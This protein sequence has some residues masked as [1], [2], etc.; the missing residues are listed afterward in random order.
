MKKKLRLFLILL[1]CL[2]TVF[3]SAGAYTLTDKF[4][5]ILEVYT[6]Y[7]LDDT[8]EPELLR[9]LLN[10][11]ITH[12]PDTFDTVVSELVKL[13]DPYSNYFSVDQVTQQQAA[14]TS[15]GIGVTLR[16]VN[17][18]FELVSV[19]E[20]TPAHYVGLKAGDVIRYINGMSTRNLTVGVLGML[21]NGEQGAENTIHFT[22]GENKYRVTLK[23][24]IIHASTVSFEALT[25]EVGYVR[26]T[27][28]DAELNTYADFRVACQKLADRGCTRLLIDV[29]DN[30]GGDTS[31]MLNMINLLVPQKGV[32]L[33]SFA[34][35]GDEKEAYHS[36]GSSLAF[37][38]VGVLVNGMSISA[39]ECMAYA[40]QQCGAATVIGQ[41]TFGKGVGQYVIPLQDGSMLS[42]TSLR[43]ENAR[44]ETYHGT[45]VKPDIEVLNTTTP[46]DTSTLLP[47]TQAQATAL[48]PGD[49]G[50]A[51]RAL[52]QRMVLMGY[53]SA[54]E[55][56]YDSQL[57]LVIKLFQQACKLEETGRIDNATYGRLN[58]T[59]NYLASQNVT[60]DVQ[61]ETALEWAGR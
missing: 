30:G 36:T 20:G 7:H 1:I 55:D 50:D 23:N 31:Q 56:V 52:Q 33:I 40:L 49:S 58:S 42:V 19:E 48:R 14:K 34:S 17:G 54:V 39:A 35:K 24:D 22:R 18:G 59:I 25:D 57:E 43:A 61:L 8:P 28:F 2:A 9:D 45:G 26:I 47:L 41:S 5:E 6:Y 10:A 51:V 12:H 3:S 15:Y 29:R 38:K 32:H 46:F 13:Y 53:L 11:L 27:S 37:E 4:N 21:F 16:A 44:G 60:T